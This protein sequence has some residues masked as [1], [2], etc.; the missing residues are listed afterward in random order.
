MRQSILTFTLLLA[1][2]CAATGQNVKINE[3]NTNLDY[4][5]ICNLDSVPVDISGWSVIYF[6]DTQVPLGSVFFFPALTILQPDECIVLTDSNTLAWPTVPAGTQILYYGVNIFW[7][8]GEAGSALLTDSNA[9]G[10][11]YYAHG[12]PNQFLTPLEGAAFFP[13]GTPLGIPT[14]DWTTVGNGNAIPNFNTG[15]PNS[16]NVHP[17]NTRIDTDG[18]DDWTEL[19]NGSDTPGVLNNFQYLTTS[20]PSGTAPAASFT[21]NT[22]S[23]AIPLLVEFTN[24][25]VGDLEVDPLAGGVILWQFDDAPIFTTALTFNSEFTYTAVGTYNPTVTLI[26]S[27]G[28][29]LTSAPVTITALIPPPPTPVA[30]TPYLEDMEGPLDPINGTAL[31]RPNGWEIV[32]SNPTSRVR[33][34][35]PSSLN[36]A[37]PVNSD[38][39][40][41]SGPN[42]AILDS[43]INSN[44]STNEIVLHLDLVS[45]LTQ[46]PAGFEFS[47]YGWDHFDET[48]PQ[49]VVV[50][51]DGITAGNGLVSGGASSG[52][53]GFGGHQEAMISDWQ[54]E[55]VNAAWTKI[56]VFIDA[57]FL[58]N[59]GLTVT[60]DARIIF[61]QNDNFMF[62]GN[63]G[64]LIDEVRVGK[65]GLVMTSNDVVPGVTSEVNVDNR[66]LTPSSQFITVVT[67]NPTVNGAFFGIDPNLSDILNSLT[68]PP[69][70][71]F[72][73]GTLDANGDSFFNLQLPFPLG[74][75]GITLNGVTLLHAGFGQVQLATSPD[76]VD[77]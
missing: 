49:D 48:H 16:Q 60:S 33:T 46:N 43:A 34:A 17:R 9:N 61:R 75:L 2:S 77:I 29:S 53:P 37:Q 23:G 72:M 44:F 19:P 30:V 56:T 1:L 20:T 11:D 69:P 42:V 74:S 45:L 28:L 47:F 63:D 39:S 25:S 3:V 76:D 57:Q 59:N 8:T 7:N 36:P 31:T 32:L 15:N 21:V 22:A 73:N 6:E 35:V 52:A 62:E 26:D 4:I 14:T 18:G 13:A 55:L 54:N 58:V 66:N 24:T 50:F 51:T 67:L 64:L 41:A 71:P 5:E 12:N 70:L 38:A 68:T 10:I 27:L 40:P 65:F